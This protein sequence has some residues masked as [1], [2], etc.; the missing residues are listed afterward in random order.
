MFGI[1]FWFILAACQCSAVSG[2]AVRASCPVQSYPEATAD[3]IQRQDPGTSPEPG[4]TAG[5]HLQPGQRQK[6]DTCPHSVIC[7]FI[8]NSET[9]SYDHN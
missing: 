5:R 3:P 6:Q 2:S 1:L 7:H 4:Q 9:E 8:F